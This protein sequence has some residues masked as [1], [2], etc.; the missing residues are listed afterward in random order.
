MPPLASISSVLS[1]T[2]AV[3]LGELAEMSRV[4]QPTATNLVATLVARGWVE[5]RADA[6]DARVSVIQNT[7][8]GEEALAAWRSELA[9]VMLPLFADL[10]ESDLATL[11]R[12]VTIMRERVVNERGI[13]S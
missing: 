13:T 5:R 2:G 12:A 1:G 9:T 8:A 4:S 6:A 3:R 11:E 10:P 7:P